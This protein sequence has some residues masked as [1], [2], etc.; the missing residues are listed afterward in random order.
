MQSAS[1]SHGWWVP[2]W[3]VPSHHIRIYIMT[4]TVVRKLC[5][6]SKSSILNRFGS[7]IR[8]QQDARPPQTN[9][10]RDRALYPYSQE[11]KANLAWNGGNR[12][13]YYFCRIVNSQNISNHIIESGTYV[14]R[15]KEKDQWCPDN[16]Y[17]KFPAL[18]FGEIG[19]CVSRASLIAPL[20]LI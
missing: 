4:R 15:Y 11:P 3:Y 20:G 14:K 19:I 6:V 7:N 2:V 13:L 16:I 8:G 10:F 17:L 5:Y 18:R 12:K 9:S 1:N